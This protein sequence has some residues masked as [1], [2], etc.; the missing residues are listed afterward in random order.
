[1]LDARVVINNPATGGKGGSANHV[2]PGSI[3]GSEV[4]A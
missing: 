2:L 4:K 3:T 1:M